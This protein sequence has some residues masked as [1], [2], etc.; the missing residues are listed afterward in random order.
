MP[1]VQIET[2]LIGERSGDHRLSVTIEIAVSAHP[3]RMSTDFQSVNL[4]AEGSGY[5]EVAGFVSRNASH[6]V[7]I[8]VVRSVLN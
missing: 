5:D 2:L 1:Q 8:R 4:K 6:G 7:V 3:V